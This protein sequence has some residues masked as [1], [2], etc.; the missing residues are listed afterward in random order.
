MK[1]QKCGAD[2]SGGRGAYVIRCEATAVGEDVTLSANE[3]IDQEALKEH[4][5]EQLEAMSAAEVER[6]VY[7]LWE[8]VLCRECRGELGEVLTLFFE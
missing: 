8:G 1:C 6:D 4:L 3:V 7:Q 5:F 2:L